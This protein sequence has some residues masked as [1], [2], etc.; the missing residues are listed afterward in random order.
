MIIKFT[1]V[2]SKMFI[3][4]KQNLYNFM[5]AFYDYYTLDKCP[6]C[7]FTIVSVKKEICEMYKL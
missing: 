7:I 5:H 3:K 4:M 2:T 6:K 1:S